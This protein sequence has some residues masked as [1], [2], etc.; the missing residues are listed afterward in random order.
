V[1]P[2]GRNATSSGWPCSLCYNLNVIF[3]IPIPEK[4]SLNKIYAGIHFRERMR[5]KEEYQYAVLYAKIAPYSGLYP[6]H[7]HYHFKLRGSRL[8]I[9]NH[10]YMSKMVA[11]ALVA[12]GVLAGDEQEYINGIT[13]T[14]EKA[15]KTGR[16][17]VTVEFSSSDI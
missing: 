10:V 3:T 17:E 9:D 5:H 1:Q 4:V 16:D 11:D 7:V 6:I 12:C 8:D 14:A 2:Q 13:I 15:P